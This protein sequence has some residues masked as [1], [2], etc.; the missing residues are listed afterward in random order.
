MHLA[1]AARS[2]RV[3]CTTPRG[4]PFLR[5]RPKQDGSCSNRRQE[6]DAVVDRRRLRVPNRHLGY[7]IYL[8][9][10]R[11]VFVSLMGGWHTCEMQA[12]H[13]PS[14]SGTHTATGKQQRENR[15]RHS[16]RCK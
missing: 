7:N 1:R 8:G 4:P 10:H 11:T 3:A 12:H 5:R 9:V 14:T 6:T 13:E 15:R 2:A 16:A